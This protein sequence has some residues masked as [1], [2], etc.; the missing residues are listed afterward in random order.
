[1]DSITKQ[2]ILDSI[3]RW[4]KR[5]DGKPDTPSVQECPLCHVFYRRHK[6]NCRGCPIE[7][8]VGKSK[9][10]GTPCEPYDELAYVLEKGREPTE[11]EKAKL[12]DLAQA[13]IDFLK[14]LL[15]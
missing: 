10:A 7:L 4:E 5:L 15:D 12:I 6:I 13:E 3:A 9:C 14:S 8:A 1:M 2:A 11:T